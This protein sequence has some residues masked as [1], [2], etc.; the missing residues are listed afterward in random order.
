MTGEA[1]VTSDPFE[2]IRG[3]MG[4]D[5]QAQGPQGPDPIDIVANDIRANAAAKAQEARGFGENLGWQSGLAAKTVGDGLANVATLLY[6]VG[7][8]GIGT[9]TGLDPVGGW[10]GANESLQLNYGSSSP[11]ILDIWGPGFGAGRKTDEVIQKRLG[12]SAALGE[13]IGMVGSF[14]LP[15]AMPGRA[16]Q[17]VARPIAGMTERMAGKLALSRAGVTGQM[18]A[19][20]LDSGQVWGYL[21]KNPG[22]ARNLGA[23]DTALQFAGRHSGEFMTATADAMARA[24]AIS[25]DSERMDAAKTAALMTPFMLPIARLGESMGRAVIQ[26]GLSQEQ[27]LAM[28]GAYESFQSGQTTLTQLQDALSTQAGLPRRFVSKLV[29]GAFEGT[30]MMGIQPGAV[31]DLRG[32]LAGD[33]DAIARLTAGWIGN[34]ASTV[35]IKAMPG[36]DPADLPFWREMRPDLN[37]LETYLDAEAARR[38]LADPIPQQDLRDQGEISA[39][40]QQADQN[41]ETQ[42]ATER[43]LNADVR[44]NADIAEQMNR[45]AAIAN[46][47][48]HQI[49]KDLRK[50]YGWATDATI[51]LLRSG[52]TPEFVGDSQVVRMQYGRDHSVEMHPDGKLVLNPGVENVLREFGKE[53]NADSPHRVVEAPDRI[54]LTG[55]VAQ[56]ALDDLAMIGVIRRLQAD[57]TFEKQGFRQVEPGVWI[58]PNGQMHTSG[59]DSST[60]RRDIGGN[61][62][63]REDLTI[64]GRDDAPVAWQHP[65][66]D[67]LTRWVVQ[68]RAMAPDGVVDPL[69][70]SIIDRASYGQGREVEQVR[71]LISSI[72]GLALVDMLGR[73]SDREVAMLIGSVAAGTGNASSV[74]AELSAVHQHHTAGAMAVPRQERVDYL[75]AM[76]GE[77]PSQP[78]V[79]VAARSYPEGEGA[80]PAEVSRTHVAPDPTVVQGRDEFMAAMSQRGEASGPAPEAN[81]SAPSGVPQGAPNTF[82]MDVANAARDLR[83]SRGRDVDV[84]HTLDRGVAA[85]MSDLVPAKSDLGIAVAAAKSSGSPIEVRVTG[86]DFEKFAR[87]WAKFGPEG[88]SKT[89]AAVDSWVRD[90]ASRFGIREGRSLSDMMRE[91]SPATV[92]RMKGESQS[93]SIG[94]GLVPPGAGE[95]ALKGSKRAGEFL[96]EHQAEVVTKAAPGD[97]L[98]WKARRAQTRKAELEGGARASF[99]SAEKAL[100]SREGRR[101]LKQNVEVP[102]LPA[103]RAHLPYWVGLGDAA[104]KPRSAVEKAVQEGIQASSLGLWEAARAAGTM[105]LESTPDGP[106]WRQ[107]PKR[108]RSVV[109]RV[110]GRD[111]ADVMSNKDLR[112]KLFDDLIAANPDETITEKGQTR[113]L[114]AQDLEAEWLDQQQSKVETR[115][116]S[117]EAERE[118]A[119]EFTRRFKHV[120]YEWRP[121]ETGR[122]YQLFET[123]PFEAMRRITERQAGRVATIEQYGQDIPKDARQALAASNDLSPEAMA[124]LGRGGTGA[125]LQ[126]LHARLLGK[127]DTSTVERDLGYAKNLLARIQGT[128]PE[129]ML[130]GMRGL[131]AFTSTTSAA[132]ASSS[133][134]WDVAEP[135]FRSPSYVG[136]ARAWKAIGSVAKS[137]REAIQ[138]ARRVGAISHEIGDWVSSEA[139]NVAK[140]A[141]SIAGWFA[142]V[143][144]RLK[145]AIATKAADLVIED[146]KAGKAT[147]NDLQVA[148]DILKLSSE[149]V[150]AIREG[151][152]SPELEAQWRR[153]LVREITSRN[154]PSEG[155]AFAAS[156]NISAM[157]RFTKFASARIGSHVRALASVA[158]AVE[159]A[160]GGIK[161]WTSAGARNAV[162]RQLKLMGFGTLVSGAIG[163]A[164]AQTLLGAFSGKPLEEGLKKYWSELLAEPGRNLW[165]SSMQ[166]VVGGPFA[167]VASAAWNNRDA[168]SL[169]QVSV[170]T[171]IL[172]A[173]GELMR[174]LRNRDLNALWNAF[175]NIGAIPMKSHF[176]AA[177]NAAQGVLSARAASSAQARLDERFVAE[178]RRENKIQPE[179][180]QRNKPAAFYDAIA[181]I[182]DAVNASGGDEKLAMQNAMGGFRKALELAPED[183]VASAIEGHQLVRALTNDQRQMLEE[184]ANDEERMARIYQHDKLLRNL[185]HEVRKMEGTNPTEWQSE[186]DAVSQQARFGGSD[187]W[188]GLVD[189]AVDETAHRIASKEAPGRQ[190]DD[191]AERMALYPDQMG[192]IFTP[193]QL[194]AIQTDRIDSLTRARRISAMLRSR[195]PDNVRNIARERAQRRGRPN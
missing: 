45:E 139:S 101:L 181:S 193:Q 98:A 8:A 80:N 2:S 154:L 3:V 182:E 97:P 23:L 129:Q 152:I 174:D 42:A 89:V 177:M 63:G 43:A 34:V 126:A 111:M 30:A 128:E 106:Q 153:E 190:I 163:A 109:E 13:A 124:N 103:E 195:L 83:A 26:N 114:T 84:M 94:A 161:G 51:P 27:A 162:V 189:R 141:S 136:F 96:F 137:P 12:S 24:Y 172:W 187:R 159:R 160:G 148:Q 167:Q 71:Q 178:F 180:G 70:L 56:R 61:W 41:A 186:L 62:T 144:E 39:R 59:L 75:K 90:V 64:V 108:D 48:M 169:S 118:A 53:P 138:Y 50:Q 31:Q 1:P 54:A 87:E 146:A 142:G 185:A 173:T 127:A 11:G 44:D 119:V 66:L 37:R 150:L 158:K 166:Q 183:S 130:P 104:A 165:E 5:G 82:R 22:M 131:Q 15:G 164:L 57:T 16:A 88:R 86:T 29:S 72:D 21:A 133:W 79:G 171:S 33:P 184:R 19:N 58:D 157:V 168:R 192:Q 116:G 36:M 149:D 7:G 69:I 155:S 74:G 40:Q 9:V 145:G 47:P 65:T 60:V 92:E 143:S 49:R 99:A 179:L 120:P 151:R 147:L 85:V 107:I 18:A 67:A 38:H 14:M 93:G 100:H 123:N 105:R 194:R 110:R 176:S 95:R 28:R 188:A 170:P 10:R 91:S 6:K 32:A 117:V 76:Q 132:M 135:A 156:P 52:W 73:N 78:D 125:A 17:S 112:S 113:K 115:G 4:R 191:L 77:P 20:I 122:V 35:A 68:K 140:K 134:I 102:G 46:H 81:P 175:S 121:T 25:P 55:P